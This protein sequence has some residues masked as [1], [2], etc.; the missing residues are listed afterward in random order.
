MGPVAN[1]GAVWIV[2]SHS[3][4]VVEFVSGSGVAITSF[5]PHSA[6]APHAVGRVVRLCSCDWL[7]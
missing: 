2:P 4:H 3:P 6:Q 5:G 1:E 7:A